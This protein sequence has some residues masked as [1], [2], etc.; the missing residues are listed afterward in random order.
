MSVK[1]TM[2]IG[3]T[4]YGDLYITAEDDRAT[5]SITGVEGPTPDG[6][7][8]GSAG[9]CID[10]LDRIVRYEP[11]WDSATAQELKA[12]W[13]RWHMNDLRAGT[14]AQEEFLRNN[15]VAAAYPVSHHTKACEALAAAGLD[16]DP[17]NGYK[18]G[19][20]WLFEPVPNEVIQW[21]NARPAGY[22][23]PGRWNQS[24]RRR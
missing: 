11:G 3:A 12:I 13:K 22:A 20:Q 19:S 16:P 9:Q 1:R 21:L 7:A 6:N 18:Y 10:A 24:S 23:L 8:Q 17:S 14:P 4:K 15:P 2:L 5:L